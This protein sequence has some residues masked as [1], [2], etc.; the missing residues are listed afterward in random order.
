MGF[1]WVGRG[2]LCGWFLV[3]VERVNVVLFFFVCGCF[4]FVVGLVVVGLG[5]F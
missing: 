2:V 3:G 5:S 4:G 1:V